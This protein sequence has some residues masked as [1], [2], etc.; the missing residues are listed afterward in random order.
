MRGHRRFLSKGVTQPPFSFWRLI[1]QQCGVLIP[2]N[3]F[4]VTVSGVRPDLVFVAILMQMASETHLEKI[5]PRESSPHCSAWHL[6]FV[7]TC[8][9]Y[10]FFSLQ[11]YF[12][13]LIEVIY[14]PYK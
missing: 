10:Q 8:P 3:I 12:L 2:S 5:G 1:W 11:L 14:I 6:E 7:V 4:Q 13:K 9:H